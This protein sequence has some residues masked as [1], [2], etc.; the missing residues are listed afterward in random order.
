MISKHF[1]FKVHARVEYII[2]SISLISKHFMF[3]V[4]KKCDAGKSN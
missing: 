3:K 2:H 4:H 1:M